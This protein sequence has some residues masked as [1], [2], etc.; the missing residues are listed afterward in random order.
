[1]SSLLE[2]RCHFAILCVSH[3]HQHQLESVGLSGL[4]QT[5]RRSE[6]DY[7]MC[8]TE[9]AAFPASGGGAPSDGPSLLRGSEGPYQGRDTEPC[10]ALLEKSQIESTMVLK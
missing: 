4:Q 5:E 6:P 2:L 7:M 10:L 9:P 3:L 8:S 1:M